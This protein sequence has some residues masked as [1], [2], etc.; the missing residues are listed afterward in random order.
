MVKK[1]IVLIV[2][3]RI[4]SLRLPKK[5]MLDVAGKPLLYRILERLKRCKR[6]NEIVVA[7]PNNKSDK[8]FKNIVKEM[9]INIFYGSE[10]NLVKRHFDAAKKFKA[11]VIVRVPGDNSIPEPEEIDKIIKYHLNIKRKSFTSNLSNIF[12]S[13]YPD[14][15]GAEVFDFLTLKQIMKRKKTLKQKEHVSLN[16]FNYKTQKN[17]FPKFCSVNTLKCPKNFKRPKLR[18]DVNTQKDY[19]FIK[20][21]YEN[22]YNKNPKFK[23][24]D[25]IKYLESK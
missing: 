12:G 21:I 11:D 6:V 14:G 19:E 13:G 20:D 9:N 22:L 23:I 15:I 18:L 2:Q 7:A 5:S 4:G 8:V 17:L 24:Q 1:K 3:V 25:V 10:K 16:F